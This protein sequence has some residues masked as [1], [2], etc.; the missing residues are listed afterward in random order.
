MTVPSL[1]LV[2]LDGWGLAEPGPTTPAELR[3]Y[4]HTY[5]E[6]MRAYNAGEVARMRSGN[7]PYL[8]RHTAF[9]VMDHAWEMQ[10]K[11]LSSPA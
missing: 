3:K 10:D 8:I 1:A 5:V 2:I 9:H 7:L 11:D 6:A 4:R